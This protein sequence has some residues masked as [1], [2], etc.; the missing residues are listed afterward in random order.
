MW[1]SKADYTA[2]VDK[3]ARAETRADWLLTQVN[4]LQHE[5]GV[6]KHEATGKPVAVPIYTKEASPPVDDT[7]ETSFEDMGDDLAHRLGVNW[8]DFGRVSTVAS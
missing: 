5:L 7:A 6:L 4:Q 8:D 1:I 3:T 2:L